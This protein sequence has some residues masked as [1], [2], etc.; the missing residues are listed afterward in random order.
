MKCKALVLTHGN[1]AEA[2]VRAV[3]LIFGEVELLQFKNLPSNFNVEQYKAEIEE[4]LNENQETGVLVLTDLLGGSPYL[5]CVQIIRN[6]WNNVELVSGCNLPMLIEIVQNIDEMSINELK[7][8]AVE[9][10]KAGIVDFKNQKK[11]V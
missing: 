7:E 4:I 10:G 6:H 2:F 1:L 5:S 11:G 9:V 8:L 3:N